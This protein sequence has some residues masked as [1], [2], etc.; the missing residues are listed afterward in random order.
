[1]PASVSLVCSIQKGSLHTELEQLLECPH[2]TVSKPVIKGKEDEPA[3]QLGKIWR[4]ILK[5][6]L[7][8]TG[9]HIYHCRHRDMGLWD[10]PENC[11]D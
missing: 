1:M 9:L 10:S 4:D 5:V 2:I 6:G 11:M 3:L 8:E 7:S